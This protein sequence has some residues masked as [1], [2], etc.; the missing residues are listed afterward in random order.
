VEDPENGDGVR[1]ALAFV[2][3]LQHE[4]GSHFAAELSGGPQFIHWGHDQSIAA[5]TRD[6]TLAI[7]SSLAG[8][9]LTAED[10]YPRPRKPEDMP[11]EAATIADFNPGAFMR[12]LTS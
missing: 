4:P 3:Q 5:D 11:Q 6:L 1:E 9:K 7:L 10:L 2:G 8:Q 12:W